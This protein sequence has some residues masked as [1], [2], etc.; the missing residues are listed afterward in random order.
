MKHSHWLD[1]NYASAYVF[2]SHATIINGNGNVTS[3]SDSTNILEL[4]KDTDVVEI[5]QNNSVFPH[6]SIVKIPRSNP[7]DLI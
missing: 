4:S 6:I 7:G 2:F 1:D 3:N 5:P